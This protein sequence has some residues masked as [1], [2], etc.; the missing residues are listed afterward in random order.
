MTNRPL[1][2]YLG[3][4]TDP[5]HEPAGNETFP[6]DLLRARLAELEQRLADAAAEKKAAVAPPVAEPALSSQ[7]ESILKRR[8]GIAPE[9]AERAREPISS[10]NRAIERQPDRIAMQAP[11]LAPEAAAASGDFGRFVDAVQ[12]IAQAASHYMRQSHAALPQ[13]RREIPA[14][15]ETSEISMLAE[16]LKQVLG[17]LHE[18]TDEFRAAMDEMRRQLSEPRRSHD[19]RPPQPRRLSRD[20]AELFRL[21]DDLD[22]LRERLGSM[23]RNRSRNPY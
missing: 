3:Q 7:I 17:A 20:D 21:Q 19:E 4:Q 12:L 16:G 2:D 1:L 15:S 23:T 11:P 10:T 18:M 9:R 14:R 22:D 13:A 5:T 8:D 6:V